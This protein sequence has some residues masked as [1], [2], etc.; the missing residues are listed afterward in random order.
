MWWKSRDPLDRRIKKLAVDML[1]EL[2]EAGW[3]VHSSEFSSR[4][5]GNWWVTLRRGDQQITITRD[6]T[7]FS[8]D[9]SSEVG[10]SQADSLRSFASLAGVLGAIQDHGLLN[11]Q[12]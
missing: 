7:E 2:A 8:L 9:G 10:F 5:F 4:F 6:R 1:A 12:P 3:T 11:R